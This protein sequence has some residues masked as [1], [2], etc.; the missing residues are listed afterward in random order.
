[1]NIASGRSNCKAI[2]EALAYSAAHRS[3]DGDAMKLFVRANYLATVLFGPFL[4]LFIAAFMFR[5]QPSFGGIVLA[6]PW[7]GLWLVPGARALRRMMKRGVLLPAELMRTR[8]VVTGVVTVAGAFGHLWFVLCMS[9]AIDL[10]LRPEWP[11]DVGGPLTLIFAMA[12]LSYLIALLCGE[13]AL[14]GNGRPDP[15]RPSSALFP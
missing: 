4:A 1:V 13:L 5:S 12:L 8:P 7:L 3:T 9:V 15:P 6:L 10:A 2:D 14:I 11:G